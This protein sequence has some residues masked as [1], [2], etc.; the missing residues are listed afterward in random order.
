MAN[1]LDFVRSG[2]SVKKASKK[3]GGPRAILQDKLNLKESKRFGARTI[4]TDFLGKVNQQ[5]LHSI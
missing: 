3:Y 5:N 1:S 2:E 4:L